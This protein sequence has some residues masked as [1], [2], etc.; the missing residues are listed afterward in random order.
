MGFDEK[1]KKVYRE[2]IEIL[3]KYE[4]TLDWDEKKGILIKDDK[5]SKD[6]LFPTNPGDIN[7]WK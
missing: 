5:S 4:L 6:I 7:Y 1:T 2:I 3:K